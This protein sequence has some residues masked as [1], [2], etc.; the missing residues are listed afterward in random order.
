MT[1][2]MRERRHARCAPGFDVGCC[3]AWPMSSERRKSPSDTMLMTS[4]KHSSLTY[5]FRCVEGHAGSSSVR[6]SAAC[7]DPVAGLRKRR[8]GSRL[9]SYGRFARDRLLLDMECEHPGIKRSM[10]KALGNV[11]GR[12]LLDQRLNPLVESHVDAMDKI[13]Q[14]AVT[15]LSRT[16]A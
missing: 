14:G 12:H 16:S 1:S 8:G 9:H 5:F 10:L 6:R 2:W 11:A 4:S 3:T 13:E 7:C 15:T